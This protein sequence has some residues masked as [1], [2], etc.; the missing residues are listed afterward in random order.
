LPEIL[1]LLE[2]SGISLHDTGYLLLAA[3]LLQALIASLLLIAL[4]LWLCK[5]KLGIEAG[6]P[7]YRRVMVYFL[8]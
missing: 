2:N 7:E 8:V 1:P 6:K 3:T 5:A 4:P